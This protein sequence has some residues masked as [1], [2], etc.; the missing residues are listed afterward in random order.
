VVDP[1]MPQVKERR[2]Q[3]GIASDRPTGSMRIDL[4]LRLGDI[5]SVKCRWRP[6]TG[7]IIALSLT[8]LLTSP[9]TCLC[10]PGDEYWDDRFEELA[11]DNLVLSTAVY[12]DSIYVG[13]VFDTLNGESVSCIAG[14][15]GESWFD[16]QGGLSVSDAYY[17]EVATLLV[18]NGSLIVAGRFDLAGGQPV[19]SIARWDGQNWHDVGG[20]VTGVFGMIRDLTTDGRYL[21]VAGSFTEAGGVPAKNVARWDGSTWTALGQGVAG[22]WADAMTVHRG[23]VYVSGRYGDQ[24]GSWMGRW[25]GT[26][27]TP[28]GVSVGGLTGTMASSSYGL[29]AS[30]GRV[31]GGVTNSVAAFNG[32]EWLP[33]GDL[34]RDYGQVDALL[35]GQ[36]SIYTGGAFSLAGAVSAT[37]VVGWDGKQSSAL[38]SGVSGLPAAD[39]FAL[40]FQSGQLIVGGSF[41]TAGGRPAS[42]FAIYHLPRTLAVKARDGRLILSWPKPDT[43]LVLETTSDPVSGDWEAVPADPVVVG[44]RLTVTNTLGSGAAFYRL[45]E[46]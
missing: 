24:G 17:A 15:D 46:R 43:S 28:I 23:E 44:Y 26:S 32:E 14:W 38:G 3:D 16:L 10:E 8:A 19:R 18:W 31:I 36:G 2:F 35:E 30:G 5:P 7:P 22:D 27:F 25:N 33:V 40:G 1:E 11:L 20:G 9:Y 34:L 4:A 29:L 6:M 12:S 41:D 21:Y 39:V 37:N 13:G 45:R 42:N